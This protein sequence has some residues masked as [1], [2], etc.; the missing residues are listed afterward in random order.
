[1][2]YVW[3][4]MYYLFY[5]YDMIWNDFV[6]VVY[7]V[8][9]DGKLIEW[10]IVKFKKIVLF[11]YENFV[12]DEE[13]GLGDWG[14]Y[15]YFVRLSYVYNKEEFVVF[16]VLWNWRDK[17]VREE[18]ESMGFVMKEYV[19]V[20]IVRVMFSDKKVFWSLLDG[21]VRNLKGRLDELFG[22]V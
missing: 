2:Y 13:I 6:V 15:N 5:V 8:Y 16:R 7:I 4:D 3:V 9:L 19:M 1:M 22:V 21:Y 12:F 14:W 17:M 11:R 20:E 10:V 18:D